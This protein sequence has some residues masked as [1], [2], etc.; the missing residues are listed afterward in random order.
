[1]KQTKTLKCIGYSQNGDGIVD[2]SGKQIE[3]PNLLKGETALIR[4]VKQ[5]GFTSGVVVKRQTTSK[6]RV[7]PPCR[8]FEQCGGCQIQHFS[9]AE[10]RDFKQK[11]VYKSLKSFGKIKSLEMMTSAQGYRNKCVHSFARAKDGTIISGLYQ[12]YS[13]RVIAI[14][15]CYIHDERADKIAATARQ[16]MTELSI[17]PYNE[18]TKKGHI[19]HLVTRVAQGTG[20]L[21][22]TIVTGS[23]ELPNKDKLIK[24][25]IKAH[26]QITGIVQN[27]NGKKTSL[28][29]SQRQKLL[30]GKAEII[31]QLCDK[32]FKIASQSFYQVNRLQTE[33]LYHYALKLADVKKHERVLDAYC[34]IG[35][36]SLLLAERAK[37]VVGVELNK[38]AIANANQNAKLNGIN[39]VE[40]VAADAAQYLKQK[41]KAKFDIVV[42]DP[43]REGC[44][45]LLIEGLIKQSPKKIVYISCNVA[46]QARDLKQ[47]KRVGYKVKQIKPFDLFVYSNHVECIVLMERK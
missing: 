1:M 16:L 5:K 22:V 24:K 41:K 9:N 11:L 33:K 18:D 15:R 12:N 31:D 19:R 36:I 26:P 14:E 40:F 27:I 21:L 38:T 10:Q 43:P 28:I 46:T 32:Q 45:K 30:Y 35:T 25:L 13:H 47:L 8:Y 42:L 4:I 34:G 3:V 7:K 44:S 20:Q 37:S 23:T 17:D 29:L 6:Q 2:D 39:N